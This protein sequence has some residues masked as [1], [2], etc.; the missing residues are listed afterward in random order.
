MS[1]IRSFPPIVDANATILI[2]G[3][4]PGVM[5]LQ[6][7]QYYAHPRNAFWP[8]VAEIAGFDRAAPYAVRI[9]RLR[10]SGIALWD[11]LH[12]CL[13]EGSLDAD[14]QK[15]SIV[16]NNFADFFI[17]QPRIRRVFFNGAKAEAV[18]RQQVLPLLAQREIERDD[19]LYSHLQYTRLP[20][21]SPAHA[22]MS[23]PL[24]LA[25]WRAIAMR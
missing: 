7:Q 18:Y 3:S 19:I 16:P 4:M 13:R 14:I 23:R 6:Q 25:A 24:K 1:I 5:S 9:D 17:A 2:L 20:S 15:D 21:T 10:Q 12:A 22:A 11:V 8:I